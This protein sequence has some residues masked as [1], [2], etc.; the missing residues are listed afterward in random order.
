MLLEPE[1]VP[2]TCWY[3]NVR[4]CVSPNDWDILRK[5]CFTLIN[6]LCE[7]C[8][9]KGNKWPVE[10]H[11]VWEYDE[12][13]KIQKLVRTSPFAHNVIKLNI[14]AWLILKAKQMKLFNN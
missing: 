1:L 6:N 14:Q 2:K 3:S 4:S 10:C 5:E 13:N 9:G 8:G 12:A 11:E 7:I